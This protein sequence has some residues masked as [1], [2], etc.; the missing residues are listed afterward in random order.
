MRYVP[1]LGYS[2]YAQLV[3][4]RFDAGILRFGSAATLHA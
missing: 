1:L 3:K 2:A 4:R